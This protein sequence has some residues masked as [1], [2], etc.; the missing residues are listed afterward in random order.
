MS[1]YKEVVKNTMQPSSFMYAKQGAEIYKIIYY[2]P[3]DKP[4]AE[5]DS[6]GAS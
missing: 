5:D 6:V 4:E 1:N 2:L 3:I